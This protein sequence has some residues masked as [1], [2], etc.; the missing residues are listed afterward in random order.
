MK[1][2]LPGKKSR[3]PT[4][5][6]NLP[7]TRSAEIFKLKI[8]RLVKNNLAHLKGANDEKSISTLGIGVPQQH[9]ISLTKMK[10][11]QC[12]GRPKI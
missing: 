12:P 8:A 4:L 2:L 6:K 9:R 11:R 5:Q 7:P 1:N 10:R 3:K